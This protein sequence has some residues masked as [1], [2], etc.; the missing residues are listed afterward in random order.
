MMMRTGRKF[1][2]ATEKQQKN[3]LSSLSNF[4]NFNF[5]YVNEICVDLRE[6]RVIFFDILTFQLLASFSKSPDDFYSASERCMGKIK[7]N[8]GLKEDFN[9]ENGIWI[10][11]KNTL[12]LWL[13]NMRKLIWNEVRSKDEIL[14]KS[15]NFV[16]TPKYLS[17]M[18]K[19]N[20]NSK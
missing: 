19:L 5:F 7:E 2:R 13:W 8:N 14:L 6:L 10:N 3:N 20:F 16:C 12:S 4:F 18:E 11:I 9:N 17:E 15:Q 1:L